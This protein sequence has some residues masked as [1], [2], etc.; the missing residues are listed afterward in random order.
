MKMMILSTLAA[1][2]LATGCATKPA[3]SAA[4]A[5]STPIA[6]A[7]FSTVV[8]EPVRIA[9]DS[10]VNDAADRE[11]LEREL[12]RSLIESIPDSLRAAEPGAKTL[13]V[14]ITVTEIEAVSPAK[15]GVSL[16]MLGMALDRGVIGFEARFYEGNSD[17]PFAQTTQRLE[18]GK[19][20]YR[21]S[22]SRYGHAAGAL[23]G[24]GTDLA[25]SITTGS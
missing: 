4:E 8:F 22:L 2:L 7:R 20:Q 25:E 17:V 11:M 3:A 6:I 18:S 24:W 12:R 23:R 15:N 16:T 13:R 9:A 5:Q 21:G 19:F 14:Q 10:G 1:T